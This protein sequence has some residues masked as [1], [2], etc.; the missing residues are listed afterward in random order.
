MS[1][2]FDFAKQC[3]ANGINI[4][5]VQQDKAPVYGFMWQ[6]D[7]PFDVM[8]Q[9]TGV[10]LVCGGE[11]GLECID[12]D[13]KIEDIDEVFGNFYNSGNCAELLASKKLIISYTQSGGYHLIIRSDFAEGNQKLAKVPLNDPLRPRVKFE[14]FI[15]TRGDNGYFVCYPSPG[16]QWIADDDKDPV[17]PWDLQKVTKETRDE[18]IELGK[19]FNRYIEVKEDKIYY[20]KQQSSDHSGDTRKPGEIYNEDPDAINEVKSLLQQEGWV[21]VAAGK[22][23]RPGKDKG[24]SATFGKVVV[25]GVVQE[26]MFYN[27]SS[28]SGFEEKGYL[29]FSLFTELKHGGRYEDAAREL[30]ERY[31]LPKEFQ[32]RSYPDAT[33]IIGKNI[34]NTDVTIDSILDELE[35]YRLDPLKKKQIPPAIL[36]FR[37]QGAGDNRITEDVNVLHEGDISLLIGEQKSK[38]SMFGT[39]IMASMLCNKLQEKLISNLPAGKNRIA[40]FD[41]EQSEYYAWKASERL[42]KLSNVHEFDFYGL[43]KCTVAERIRYIHHYIKSTPD[44]GMVLIDGPVDLVRDPNDYKE[45]LELVQW[46]MELTAETKCHIMNILHQNRGNKEARGF[47]G[48]VL[49][50]KAETVIKIER[51]EDFPERSIVSAKDTR[52]R[53]FKEF[54]IE[55]NYEGMPEIVNDQIDKPKIF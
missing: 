44:L 17:M 18:L 32:G 2:L 6:K 52:G 43:R 9:A 53:S 11:F 50:Q 51:L 36:K 3:V 10:G 37:Q 23:R 42:Y 12:F 14:A 31:N 35:K 24:I 25:G 20:Q 28:N 33:S 45:A 39:M 41:T 38:K 15:E 46:Q 19:S 7:N 29:P 30:A 27:F 47:I 40:V 16:Y 26:N 34:E 22:W 5:P 21:E 1:E 55:V 54:E 49:A 8:D 13:R 48:L 4:V